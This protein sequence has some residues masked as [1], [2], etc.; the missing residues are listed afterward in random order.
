MYLAQADGAAFGALGAGGLALALTVLLVLGVRGQ[1]RVRLRENPAL[2]CGFIAGTAFSAAGAIWSN[3]ERLTQQGLT[4]LGVGS[5][6]GPF[7]NVGVGAVSLIL[8]ILMLC[9]KLTPVRGAGLGLV[10][11]VVWPLAGSSAVWALPVELAAASL[12]MIGG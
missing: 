10:A 3:P 1:G 7:G 4:G 9:W 11:A 12:M 8:L 5:E 6:S 2:I